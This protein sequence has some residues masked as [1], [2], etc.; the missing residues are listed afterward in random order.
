MSTAKKLIEV[1]LPLEAI[2][3]ASAREKSIRHGHPSTLHIWWA[4]RP[5]AAA[6]A[7]IFASLV[8]DPDDSHASPAFVAACRNLRYGEEASPRGRL[9]GFIERLVQ[10]ES[11]NNDE[12]MDEARRLIRLATGG[13]PPALLDPFAGGGSIPLEAQRLGLTAHA[14][15]L[16]PVAVMLNKAMIEIPPRF[17]DCRPVNPQDG[18]Q[19]GKR[20]WKG[21]A[22][23]AADVRYYGEWMRERA[24][25]KIGHLYPR[26]QG[27][28]VIAWLW[29][30][31]VIS[32]NPAVN[33]PVP[34]VRSFALSKRK[35]RECWAKPIIQGTDIRFE[36]TKGLPP[37]GQAGTMIR[38]QGAKC[39]ISGEPISFAY[40]RAQG[41]AGRLGTQLMAIVTQGRRGRNYHSPTAEAQELA[42]SAKPEWRPR[43][44]LPEK[45]LGF[46]AQLYGLD[47][48]H[49]LFTPRQLVALTAFSDLIEQ[50]WEG[51]RADAIAAGWGADD[52]H[53]RDGGRG[54]C[55][56]GEA[57]AVYL[58]LAIGRGNDMW[59]N[60]CTWHVPG[61]KISHLFARQAIPI[62]W[63]YAEANP[64]SDSTGNWGSH[65]NWIGKVLERLPARKRG[66][67]FANQED[68][69]AYPQPDG[70]AAVTLSTDPPYYDNIGYADLSDFFYVWLRR[71]LRGIYPQVFGTLLVPKADE[72]IAAPYRQGDKD[73]AKDYFESGMRRTFANLRQ[74][75]SS[76]YP[77]TVYY[78]F[79]Q[80]DT[81]FM[82]DGKAAGKAS[83]GWETMLTSLIQAG[84]SIV[85]TWPMRTE[86]SNRPNALRKNALASSIVLVC[87]PRAADAPE[88]SRRAFVAELRRELPKALKAMQ[89]GYI[90]PVDLAQASI[91]PGMA[92]Y[93]RASRILEADGRPMSV[94]DALMLINAALDEYLAER[95]GDLDAE[96][97]FAVDW[98]TQF[99]FAA[100]DFGEADVLA[101]AKNTSVDSVA[102]AGVADAAGGKVSLRHWSDYDPGV[103]HPGED[104][105]PTVWEGTHH[106]IERLNSHGESGA[107]ALLN[108]MGGDMAGEARQ[109]AYRLYDICERRGRAQDAYHYNT[110]IASWQEISALAAEQRSRPGQNS[111]FD[112]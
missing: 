16:N 70:A 3:R 91:G 40:I 9:F 96:S 50:A 84:F 79:K 42:R 31:T 88:R 98:F 35:G 52:R 90:A 30:R 37:K 103:W 76:D 78:A 82:R 14:S 22:G 107:A 36:V 33:A 94:R 25:E 24:W 89:S 51:A 63:D 43:G 4:R 111:L 92:I 67:G 32:P 45:A 106:L 29:A 41:R 65:L 2:N 57:V 71:N 28:T 61:E 44:D 18:G 13:E 26:H 101:R 69:A 108:Q 8:D 38:R 17:A 112:Q 74:F 12:V 95:D 58:A 39:L 19:L 80:Q 68:A 46:V 6:R 20:A 56:Y 55:A 99:G 72:L 83:S 86:K 85:G 93:S 100:G 34:L 10:W 21:A 49:K 1:A 5:L 48:W 11:T 97:R 62:V 60:L 66:L 110:L 75:V 27:E 73:A 87:R 47:E 15:D 105:R 23:L 77:L 59:S 81:G 102:L 54:A 64:F 104:D 53:L 7:V 109:L